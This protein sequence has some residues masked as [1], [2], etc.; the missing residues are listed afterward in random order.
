M[1]FQLAAFLPGF[2]P[3]TE[4]VCPGCDIIFRYCICTPPPAS[5]QPQ[6]QPPPPFQSWEQYKHWYQDQELRR[7]QEQYYHQ[8]QQQQQFYW[9]PQNSPSGTARSFI[10]FP[11][12][13]SSGP[14]GLN[15]PLGDRTNSTS[16]RRT[17]T[18]TDQSATSTATANPRPSRRR[19]TN[20]NAT[21]PSSSAT[22]SSIAQPA[23]AGVGPIFDENTDSIPR[24][25]STGTHFESVTRKKTAGRTDGASHCWWFV[26]GLTAD[27]P[28]IS[29]PEVDAPSKKR[30][31]PK[32]FSH[33]G[34]RLC[35]SVF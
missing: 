19:R 7:Q 11:S 5:T 4:G 26:R 10:Q 32:D 2:M 30:P 31:S 27:R 6:S 20:A 35:Q 16:T 18:R 3:S 1:F 24:A 21:P 22:P 13:A 8:Q 29:I 12:P 14:G 34:C 25:F 23:V 9:A 28:P 15:E 17:R 33:L